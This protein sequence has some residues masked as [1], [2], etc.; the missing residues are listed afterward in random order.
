[1][2]HYIAVRDTLRQIA[3]REKVVIV[4]RG[5]GNAGHQG[6]QAR[7]RR[8]V[9]G[10]VRADEAGYTCLAQYVARAIARRLGKALAAGMIGRVDTALSPPTP[11]F[12]VTPP[13]LSAL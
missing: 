9:A 10:R 8:A 5:R 3:A 7:R 12:G 2:E 1:M 6:G 4:R 11:D 13:A